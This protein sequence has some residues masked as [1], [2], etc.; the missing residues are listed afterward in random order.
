MTSISAGHII[1]T[2][3]QPVGSG[4]PQ[5]ES[6]PGPPHQESRALPTELPQRYYPT[7]ILKQILGWRV[8]KT[9]RL[10][11]RIRSISLDCGIHSGCVMER[12]KDGGRPRLGR[13]IGSRT[14]TAL[15]FSFSQRNVESRTQASPLNYAR[16]VK[17][18][19]RERDREREREREQT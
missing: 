13:K 11:H 6:N 9:E 14:E 19:E 3:T 10:H 4:Q 12:D 17:T 1:L 18:S 7:R 8:A 5:R 2:P 16:E 15:L